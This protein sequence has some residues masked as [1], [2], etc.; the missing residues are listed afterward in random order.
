MTSETRTNRGQTRGQFLI[1]S[2]G[3]WPWQGQCSAGTE[4]GPWGR[5]HRLERGRG[6]WTAEEQLVIQGQSRGGSIWTGR[7]FTSTFLKGDRRRLKWQPQQFSLANSPE[8]MTH[9]RWGGV[10]RRKTT[11]AQKVWFPGGARLWALQICLCGARISLWAGVCIILLKTTAKA[12][13]RKSSDKQFFMSSTKNGV[14]WPRPRSPLENG[15]NS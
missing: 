6:H 7:K 14:G 13:V 11:S 1:S 10:G 8:G 15:V 9:L 5:G 12:Q 3:G 4:L 2:E